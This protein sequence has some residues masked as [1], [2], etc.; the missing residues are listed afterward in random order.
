MPFSKKRKITK[1]WRRTYDLIFFWNVTVSIFLGN[2]QF[3]A[4][5]GLRNLKIRTNL[6]TQNRKIWFSA[7]TYE[8]H[9]DVSSFF[10]GKAGMAR[11]RAFW[12]SNGVGPPKKNR[13]SSVSIKQ[14]RCQ[15]KKRRMRHRTQPMRLRTRN[16]APR[17]SR[18]ADLKTQP[19]DRLYDTYSG[20]RTCPYPSSTKYCVN[21]N[22]S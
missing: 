15:D 14:Y 12:T 5:I 6:L 11:F 10:V 20:R 1:S 7:K 3:R 13:G 18:C 2:Y 9:R 22:F 21:A 4:P 17:A 8:N 19:R 16:C